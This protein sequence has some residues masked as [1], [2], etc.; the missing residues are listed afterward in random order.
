MESNQMFK[1]NPHLNKIRQIML[2]HHYAYRT[3]K[4]KKY[5]SSCKSA[6]LLTFT[7]IKE[8]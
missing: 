2:Y 1:S 6:G 3:E 7:G 8:K 5:L 4:W